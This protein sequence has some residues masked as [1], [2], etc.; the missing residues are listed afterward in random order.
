MIGALVLVAAGIG[1]GAAGAE[2]AGHITGLGGVFV[3]SRDQ[4]ALA[5]WYRDVLGISLESLGGAIMRY[6]APGHPRWRCGTRCPN[7]A[8]S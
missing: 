7:T 4:K 8:T 5:T 1:A 3:T 2:P 6:G